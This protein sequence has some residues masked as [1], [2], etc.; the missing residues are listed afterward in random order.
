MFRRY[1]TEHGLPTVICAPQDLTFRDG[2]LLAP[3]PE[4]GDMS[5]TIVFKRV[6]TSEFPL[7]TMAMKR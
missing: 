3:T 6:L 4:G 1:F 7:L 5:V 2:Q